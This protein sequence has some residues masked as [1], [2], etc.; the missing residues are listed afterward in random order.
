MCGTKVQDSLY[1]YWKQDYTLGITNLEVMIM[2]RNM[3][4]DWFSPTSSNYNGFI[5]ALLKNDV[6]AAEASH[7]KNVNRNDSIMDLFW[8]LWLSW[9]IAM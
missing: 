7:L 4:R 8:A 5:Q 2:F 9:K 3:V 6:E 1:E